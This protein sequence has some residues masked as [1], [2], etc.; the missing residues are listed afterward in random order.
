[1]VADDHGVLLAV[2]VTMAVV[3]AASALPVVG[4]TTTRPTPPGPAAGVDD[5]TARD[6]REQTG[7]KQLP[8]HRRG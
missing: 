1:M 6:E 4:W 7:A 3:D 2:T 8:H 5:A